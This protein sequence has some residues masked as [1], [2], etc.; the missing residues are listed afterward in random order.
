MNTWSTFVSK[1]TAQITSYNLFFL[2][3][4]HTAVRSATETEENTNWKGRECHSM[5]Q[6]GTR[7]RSGKFPGVCERLLGYILSQSVAE[8]PRTSVQSL[9]R[10]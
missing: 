6:F 9:R 7:L 10:F 8:R 5:Q 4:T 3:A 1:E 2:I